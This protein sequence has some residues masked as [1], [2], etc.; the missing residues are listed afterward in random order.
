MIAG[1]ILEP[2]VVVTTFLQYE[3]RILL[4]QRSSRV[5]TYQGC[6]SAV[7]GYLED[8]K[9]LLQHAGRSGRRPGCLTMKFILSPRGSRLPYLRQN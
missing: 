1:T 3:G 7:S 6:W 8:A 5:G 2:T 4:V 9:P